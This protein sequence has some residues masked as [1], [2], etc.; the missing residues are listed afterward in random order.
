M[1]KQSNKDYTLT[2]LMVV[3]ASREINDWEIVF[4]GVGI[5]CL[6]AQLS[7]LTHAPHSEIVNESGVFG[8]EARRIIL[9]IGDNACG[10]RAKIQGALWRAFSDQQVGLWDVGMLG[11][12]QIDKYGNLNSTVI[13]GKG[14]YY[15]PAVR[16]SGSGGANDIA[17][18]AK[19]TMIMIRQERR[20]FV[21]RVDYITSPGYIDGGDSR[22]KAGLVGGGPVLV[23]TD[24]ATFRFDKVTKEMYLDSVHP[25]VTVEEAREVGW[26]LKVAEQVK[27]TE[28]PSEEEIRIIR[29]LDPLGIYTGNGLKAITFEQYIQMLEEQFVQLYKLYKEKRD[30]IF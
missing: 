23:I 12:A 14:D 29:M 28:S 24:K 18:S 4:A 9:G 3:A 16:L 5:P 2:E 7:T 15:K 13:F 25:G 22:K 27:T 26:D 17:S 20:R 6:S 10:E 30:V 19:R 11:G 8:G 1:E 21:E